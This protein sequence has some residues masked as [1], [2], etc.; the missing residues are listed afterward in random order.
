MDEYPPCSLDHCLPL[1]VVLGLPSK[2]A[3][4]SSLDYQY[5]D[6]A[7]LIR[8]EPPPVEGDQVGALIQHIRDTDASGLPWNGRDTSNFKYKFRFRTTGR[9]RALSIPRGD[10]CPGGSVTMAVLTIP[11]LPPTTEACPSSRRFRDPTVPGRVTLAL[12]ASQ[13]HGEPLSR[14]FDRSGMAQETSRTRTERFGV[15]L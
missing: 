14:W 9:V 13:P 3:Q 4:E 15:P 7:T 5:K 2:Y 12:F 6:G 8:S 1:A 11:D 10:G